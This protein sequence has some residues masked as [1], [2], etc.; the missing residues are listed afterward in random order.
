VIESYSSALNVADA[1]GDSNSANLV[2]AAITNNAA[3]IQ[4]YNML[5]NLGRYFKLQGNQQL[6]T[7]FLESGLSLAQQTLASTT[8]P[9]QRALIHFRILRRMTDFNQWQ[10]IFDYLR[11]DSAE[12]PGPAADMNSDSNHLQCYAYEAIAFRRSSNET[13]AAALFIALLDRAQGNADLEGKFGED[14][15][16]LYEYQSSDNPAAFDLFTWV[17]RKYPSHPWANVGR[18]ELAVQAFNSRDFATARKLA[19]DITNGLT[20]NSKMKWIQ[21]TYWSAVYL[22]GACLQ[23]EGQPSESQRLKQLALSE[24]PGLTI[25]NRL[26]TMHLTNNG[27]VVHL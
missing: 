17:A 10:R 8:D 20:Q 26:G 7:N 18:L 12:F 2:Y 22:R 14:L 5:L 24:F 23:A 16:M 21:R 15:A 1:L 13:N 6:A 19:D 9:A 11:G 25:Q 27:F 3:A 4:D